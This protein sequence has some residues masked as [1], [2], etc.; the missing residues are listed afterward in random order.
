M[1]TYGQEQAGKYD[2]GYFQGKLKVNILSILTKPLAL[3]I[4][5][6]S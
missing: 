5:Q 2:N 3:L 6:S 4:A 1:K